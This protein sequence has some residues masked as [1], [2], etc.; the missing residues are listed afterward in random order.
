[1]KPKTAHPKPSLE[2]EGSSEHLSGPALFV[3]IQN[4]EADYEVEEE[5]GEEMATET[6]DGP[7]DEMNEDSSDKTDEETG[8]EI[9]VD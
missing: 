4:E 6:D 5:V 8:D 3:V 9:D 2:R 7:F 1:M